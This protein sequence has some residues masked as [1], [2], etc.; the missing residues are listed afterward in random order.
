MNALA[1]NHYLIL[2]CFLLL[3]IFGTHGQEI[4][5][6][7]HVTDSYNTPVNGARITLGYQNSTTSPNGTA[8][9]QSSYF[10]VPLSAVHAEFELYETVVVLTE[11]S[12]DTLHI[13]I[14]LNRKGTDL[15][16]IVISSQPYT[17]VYPEKHIHIIDFELFGNGFLILCKDNQQ[18]YLRELD[19]LENPVR[20]LKIPRSPEG[21]YRDCTDALHILYPDSAYQ[22]GYDFQGLYLLQGIASA[23]LHEVLD[24]CTLNEHPYFVFSKRGSHNKAVT[25]FQLDRSSG[26]YS[27]LYSTSDVQQIKS[28]DEYAAENGV[29][30]TDHTGMIRANTRETL[31]DERVRFQNREHYRQNLSKPLYAPLFRFGDSLCIYDHFKD[32]ATLFLP[33]GKTPVRFPISYHYFHNW[34]SLLIQNYERTRMFA[35]YEQEGLALLREIDPA[36]G[37]VIG[38]TLIQEHVY[39]DKMQIRGEFVYYIFHR[40]I[41]QSINYIYKQRI[42]HSSIQTPR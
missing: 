20:E 28:L 18:Y 21:F 41:D 32:S 6:L 2:C 14:Q 31:S 13:H 9:F 3:R 26:E 42:G 38:T 1:M 37:Q 17:L 15:D 35:T 7:C 39:P 12:S 16:E 24:P 4:T 34:K 23:K 27:I 40:Y 10:P 19:A 29:G 11:P 33:S 36:T 22:I 8:G 5:V 30:T 25:Y